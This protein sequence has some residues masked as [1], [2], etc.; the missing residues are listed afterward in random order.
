MYNTAFYTVESRFGD[1]VREEHFNRPGIVAWCEKNLAEL[2]R[3]RVVE[4]S[5]QG[6]SI[7]INALEWWETVYPRLQKETE[8]VLKVTNTQLMSIR[9]L[10]VKLLMAVV[11]LEE[12]LGELD[13]YYGELPDEYL[14][15]VPDTDAI[16]PWR[17]APVAG[18]E[19]VI[20]EW[21]GL[22]VACSNSPKRG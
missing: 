10:Q 15:Q 5:A 6:G 18:K 17:Y 22:R 12:W 8:A 7:G 16:K 1:V 20:V 11:V 2:A 14:N 19:Q 9:V 4:H 21:A 3:W 13:E